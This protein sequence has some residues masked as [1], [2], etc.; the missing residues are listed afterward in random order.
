MDK[1]R[2]DRIVLQEKQ[3]IKSWFKE[4]N[5]W[6]GLIISFCIIGFFVY[7]LALI[8]PFFFM[9]FLIGAFFISIHTILLFYE[10]KEI[11]QFFIKLIDR[12]TD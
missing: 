7:Y 12:G 11:K 8:S 10:P 1:Q 5:H 2:G 4:N 3:G 9:I 6:V